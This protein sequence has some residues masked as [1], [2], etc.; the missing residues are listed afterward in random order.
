[1]SECC[2]ADIRPHVT[3]VCVR[4][5]RKQVLAFAL[6]LAPN[7]AHTILAQLLI[8]SYQVRA[9]VSRDVTRDLRE[10][11][12]RVSSDKESLFACSS[13]GGE[14]PGN[15]HLI[16]YNSQLRSLSSLKVQK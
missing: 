9:N 2:C 11:H 15:R 3:C 8:C 12:E 7:S 4:D 5:A 1:M 13:R 10:S 14:F 16:D 6:Y